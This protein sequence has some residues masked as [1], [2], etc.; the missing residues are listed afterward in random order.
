MFKLVAIGIYRFTSLIGKAKG[1]LG[2]QQDKTQQD[3]TPNRR[4][5][6]PRK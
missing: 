1:R 2:N 6:W 5:D 4:D 3:T